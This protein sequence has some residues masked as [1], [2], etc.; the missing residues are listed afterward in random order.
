MAAMN[1]AETIALPMTETPRRWTIRQF[2]ILVAILAPLLALARFPVVLGFVSASGSIAVFVAHSI[3]RR[4]F[5]RIAWLVCAFPA[6][7]LLT[8]HLASWL[9]RKRMIRRSSMGVLDGVLGISD[10]G[11]VLCLLVFLASLIL[12]VGGRGGRALR[13]AAW[14]LVLILP[15]AWSSFVALAIWDPFGALN[16]VFRF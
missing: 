15:L 8:I 5:D 3:R 13:R 12:L 14:Q 16:V 9:L 11:A 4:H 2:M 10:I 6:V 7:P 1:P